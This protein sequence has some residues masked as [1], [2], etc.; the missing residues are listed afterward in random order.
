M[1]MRKAVDRVAAPNEEVVNMVRGL[2]RIV[3]FCGLLSVIAAHPS[4]TAAQEDFYAGKTIRIIVGSPPGGG[5][6]LYARLLA[7]HLGRH[8]PG[9]P[10]VLVQNM[11]GASSVIA[12]NYVYNI[13]KPDGLTIAQVFR[14]LYTLQLLE[15]PSSKFDLNE[16][17]WLGSLTP[18]LSA[19]ILHPD[20]GIKTIEDAKKSPRPIVLGASGKASTNYLYGRL[21]EHIFGVPFKYVLGYSGTS[22]MLAAVER[23]ELDGFG[24]RSISN[25]LSSDRDFI[26]R[27]IIT[28]IIITG[29]RRHPAFPDVPTFEE[30][31][32]HAKDLK[33]VD[34]VL[35][36]D[37]WARPFL[38]G[39]G[40]PEDR[41]KILRDAFTKTVNDPKFLKDAAKIRRPIDPMNGEELQQAIQGV[42][43]SPPQAIEVFRNFL[44]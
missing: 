16:V 9:Q 24:G 36:G 18:E 14:D 1:R 31:V 15:D 19:L 6:D 26:D 32:S 27:G 44:K 28:P 22:A 42:L 38:V 4:A 11:P 35:G 34:L 23:K 40:V 37:R 17:H 10:H 5:Y 39:P 41:V 13:A 3:A 8:I 33:L 25:L 12:M 20:L 2:A 29:D 21:V 30:E 43:N 7:R